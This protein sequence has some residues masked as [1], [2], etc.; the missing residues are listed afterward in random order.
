MQSYAS[1][2]DW[3]KS[4]VSENSASMLYPRLADR[5]LQI[6][7]LDRAI[8]FAEKGVLLHPHYATAR[9]VMAKCYYD[10]SQF[11]EANKHLKEAL[12]VDP[13]HLGALYLQSELL[14]KLGD[15]EKVKGNYNLMLDIDPF[16]DDI[17]QKLYDLQYAEPAETPIEPAPESTFEPDDFLESGVGESDDFIALTDQGDSVIPE[18]SLP[19]LEKELE[20]GLEESLDDPFDENL[21]DFQSEDVAQTDE[22]NP[23]EDFN[24]PVEESDAEYETESKDELAAADTEESKIRDEVLDES[25][26]DDFEI[27]RSKYKEEESRFT[28]LLDNIFSSSI[29][30]EEQAESEMR[31]AIERMAN[32]DAVKPSAGPRAFDMRSE[33]KG[34]DRFEPLMP[35]GDAP[36]HEEQIIES[37]RDEQEEFYNFDVDMEPSS[38]EENS[39]PEEFVTREEEIDRGPTAGEDEREEAPP[40]AGEQPTAEE[41]KHD[42]GE[43]LSSLDIKDDGLEEETMSFDNELPSFDLDLDDDF[44]AVDS[45]QAERSGDDWLGPQSLGEED[46]AH[47]GEEIAST[48]APAGERKV[49]KQEPARQESDAAEGRGKGK[50][51]RPLLEKFTPP[52]A[53]IQKQ[54]LYLRRS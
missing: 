44:P 12:A 37:G 10:N 8:E 9:Y 22:A 15:F 17:H 11:D 52:R 3:L 38:E 46:D 50:F 49:E 2:I 42:F 29:D 13:E 19:D 14:K 24:E 27:D 30:E 20:K 43:F 39:I 7:E 40:L 32:E 51:I 33:E 31:N 16:N 23:F 47:K 1:E 54:S 34:G 25:I 4:K 28:E 35:P 21:A 45:S 41:P 53:S 26:D 48:S 36:T 18:T 6:N 5:Y